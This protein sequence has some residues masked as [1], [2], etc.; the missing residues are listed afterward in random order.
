MIGRKMK[1][2]VTIKNID[3]YKALIENVEKAVRALSDFQLEMEIGSE[4]E[5]K[6]M[7]KELFV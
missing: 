7:P 6:S 4:A 5:L 1:L 3:D 2:V